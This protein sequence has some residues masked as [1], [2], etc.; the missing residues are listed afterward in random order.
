MKAL[1]LVGAGVVIPLVLSPTWSTAIINSAIFGLLALSMVVVTGYA[2]QISLAA[3]ALAGFG[4]FIAAHLSSDWNLPFLAC[5]VL[6]TLAAVI[7]GV[8]VGAPTVK[9]PGNQPG[10]RHLGLVTSGRR[11]DPYPAVPH[12]WPRGPN[13]A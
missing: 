10:H 13:C 5:I 8:I 7:L 3:A 1:F 2:G 4:S 6:G 12:W 9:S 11:H